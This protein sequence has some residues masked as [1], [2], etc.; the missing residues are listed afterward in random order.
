[1]PTHDKPPMESPFE[2]YAERIA[3]GVP[4]ELLVSD[5]A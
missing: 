3:V 1:V 4:I 5:T 2:T